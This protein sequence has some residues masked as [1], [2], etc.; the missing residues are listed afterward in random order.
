[1][2]MQ[3]A[4]RNQALRVAQSQVDE[5]LNNANNNP[6]TTPFTKTVTVP[7]NNFSQNYT[8][9]VSPSIE[10]Q[11]EVILYTVTVSWVYKGQTY[12]H[13]QTTAVHL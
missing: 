2:N 1:L 5:I 7:I 3:N 8:V 4:L 6:M 9:S 10:P 13:T 12:Y 11:N